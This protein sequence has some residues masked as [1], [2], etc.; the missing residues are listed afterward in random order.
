VKGSKKSARLSEIVR[1]QDQV[2]LLEAEVQALKIRLRLQ[3]C[4]IPEEVRNAHKML[5]AILLYKCGGETVISDEALF[6]HMD[7]VSLSVERRAA[8]MDTVIRAFRGRREG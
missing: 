5:A 7:D 1:L 3:P 4:S 2:K 6:L 8:T